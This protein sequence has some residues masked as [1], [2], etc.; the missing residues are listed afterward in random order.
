MSTVCCIAFCVSLMLAVVTSQPLFCPPR[1][2]FRRKPTKATR[3]LIEARCLRKSLF[4]AQSM[5]I[6]AGSPPKDR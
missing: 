1:N 6:I 5:G 4:R 2:H 3:S